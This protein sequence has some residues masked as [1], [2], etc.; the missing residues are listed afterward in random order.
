MERERG[1]GNIIDG[2]STESHHVNYM[3]RND[4]TR[5]LAAIGSCE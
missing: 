5:S 3:H 4:M 2:M 1:R